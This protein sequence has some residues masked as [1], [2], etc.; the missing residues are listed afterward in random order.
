VAEF[1]EKRR[2]YGEA[3]PVFQEQYLG[4]WVFYSGTVYGH[5]FD[6]A[7]NIRDAFTIPP[8]WRRIRGIDFGYRDPFVCLW[9]AV[10]EDSLEHHT[11]KGELILYREY[12]Q[13]GR[14]MA[15][16]AEIIKRLTGDEKVLY[17]VA[18]ESEAQSIVDLRRFGVPAFP[19]NRDRRAGRL[20]VGNA[21]RSGKLTLLRGAC[22]KT[23]SELA[24]YRWD[25][26]RDK[27]GAKELTIGDDHAMDA[28]RYAVMSR[29]QPRTLV[30]RT[31]KGSFAYEMQLQK[32]ERDRAVWPTMVR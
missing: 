22:P 16:H 15:E 18:D 26:D 6:P 28:M 20:L 10:A 31:P 25:R 5:D 27:E 9:F 1:D 30:N 29:P 4:K 14:A 23:V 3:H 21:F 12:Y 32:L 19:S 7:R 8:E 13:A 17:T 2:F 24:F 11:Q